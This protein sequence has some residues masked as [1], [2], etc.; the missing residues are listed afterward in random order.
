MSEYQYVFK[1]EVDLQ[2]T[3]N[4]DSGH[5]SNLENNPFFIR[6]DLGSL[7]GF[8]NEGIV[9]LKCWLTCQIGIGQESKQ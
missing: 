1:L 8:Q 4:E 2:F 5:E 3:D 7:K 6:L 9:F